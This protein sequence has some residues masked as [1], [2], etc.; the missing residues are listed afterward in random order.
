MAAFCEPPMLTR[1]QSVEI[2]LLAR[3]GK[4]IRAIARE[5]GVSRATVR[6]YLTDPEAGRYG[7]RAP[8]PTK[9]GPFT[10]YLRERIAA[11]RPNWIPA[12]V[13]LRELRERGYA[14][15]ISQLKAYLRPLKQVRPE[16]VVNGWSTPS[17][18]LPAPRQ[19]WPT[20]RAT[21]TAWPSP[22][23]GC[24]PST[25]KVSPSAGRTIGPRAKRATRP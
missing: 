4:G 1:E 10:D 23:A 12:T 20:Y 2:R 21:P 18:R 9:L 22:T 8:R 5:L 13:L 6:R 25:S 16:P 19:C 3:Q 24:S 7:P 14:G 15:G 17:G 11:A